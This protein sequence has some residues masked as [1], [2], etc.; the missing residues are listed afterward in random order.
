MFFKTKIFIKAMGVNTVNIAAEKELVTAFFCGKI[1]SESHHFLTDTPPATA[2]GNDNIFDD[3]RWRSHVA[4]VVH[5]QQGKSSDRFTVSFCQVNT[6]I[7]DAQ[8]NTFCPCK[9]KNLPIIHT[10][11]TVE[12]E[13]AGKIL[14]GCFPD[15]DL[16]SRCFNYLF[17]LFSVWLYGGLCWSLDN[18]SHYRP[19]NH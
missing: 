1:G 18:S 10:E 7:A 11:L 3:C 9:R 16:F 15:L 8:K 4:K 19:G 13:Q 12:F 14:C 5:D 2:V 6:I 17:L